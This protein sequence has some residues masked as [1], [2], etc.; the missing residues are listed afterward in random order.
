LGRATH[1]FDDVE[2]FGPERG[3]KKRRDLHEEKKREELR[4]LYPPEQFD[5]TEVP[6]FGQ[7]KPLM[8]SRNVFFD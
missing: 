7:Y 3:I 8:K 2:D 1:N 5:P 6:E 4:E